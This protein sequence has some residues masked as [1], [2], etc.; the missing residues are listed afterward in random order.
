MQDKDWS[1]YISTELEIKSINKINRTFRRQWCD[2]SQKLM[3]DRL[4]KTA[5]GYKTTG[6]RDVDR[7]R[8]RRSR[9]RFIKT[10]F[11]LKITRTKLC[12]DLSGV[13]SCK[14]VSYTHLDV[15]KRQTFSHYKFIHFMCYNYD[16]NKSQIDINVYLSSLS[17]KFI[18]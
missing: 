7:P 10:S 11:V 5:F 3:E 2:Q 16:Y 18:N 12:I 9:K 13:H 14:P 6:R 4:S 15:Y 8:L 1:E 17:C